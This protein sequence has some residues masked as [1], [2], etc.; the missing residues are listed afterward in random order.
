M[1]GGGALMQEANL[2]VLVATMTGEPTPPTPPCKGGEGAG[3]VAT[4]DLHAEGPGYSRPATGE[5]RRVF[6]FDGRPGLLGFSGF[7]GASSSA[8]MSPIRRDGAPSC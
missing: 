8:S 1:A 2:V 6:G 4:R 7:A 5:L 3:G